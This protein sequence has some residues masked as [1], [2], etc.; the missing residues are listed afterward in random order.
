MKKRIL[1]VEKDKGIREVLDYLLTDEGFDVKS[2][3]HLDGIINHIEEYD[4]QVILFDIVVP[5]VEDSDICRL[6]KTSKTTKHVPVI[7]L[8]TNPKVT[9]TIKDVCADEVISKPFDIEE[10]LETIENQIAA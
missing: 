4:P 2:F 8:S 3:S 10:L 7:V 9:A 6:I 5:G 1:I